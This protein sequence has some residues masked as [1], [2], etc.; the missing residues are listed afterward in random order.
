MDGFSS[1]V[2]Y[3]LAHKQ[4]P[5]TS[6]FYVADVISG[7]THCWMVDMNTTVLRGI[8]DKYYSWAQ[9]FIFVVDSANPSTL[10]GAKA[11][12]HKVINHP[13]MQ[14]ATILIYAY[15]QDNPE[16]L[17][18]HEIEGKLDL[19][20]LKDR[21]WHLQPANYENDIGIFEGLEW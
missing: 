12:I 3:Q 6:G 16:A 4:I 19:N 9:D 15:R 20:L 17:K 8:W 11:D 18:P 21:I 14:D 1:E 13:D 2:L 5:P 7:N 10:E